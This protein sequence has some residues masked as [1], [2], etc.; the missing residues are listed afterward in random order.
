[1]TTFLECRLRLVT[2]VLAA[3]VAC[4]AADD[5]DHSA[6][7]LSGSAVDYDDGRHLQTAL[8]FNPASSDDLDVRHSQRRTDVVLPL[9]PVANFTS[10]VE[11][12]GDVVSEDGRTG[13][14]R[15][16]QAIIVGVKK[17]GTRA[18]LEFLRIHPHVRAPGPEVH[19]FDRHYNR[20][21]DW[22]RSVYI[23]FVYILFGGLVHWC[24]VT[25][26]III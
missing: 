9:N 23:D 12:A 19:F 11:D 20:G 1:M 10:A 4:A 3:L 13:I 5:D 15:L 17:G 22:Y 14:R 18:L 26:F 8:R 7:L 21:L 25:V 2:V 24:T 6:T 16:P